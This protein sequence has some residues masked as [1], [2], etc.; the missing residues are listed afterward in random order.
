MLGKERAL[1]MRAASVDCMGMEEVVDV[2]ERLVGGGRTDLV[3][4]IQRVR[5]LYVGDF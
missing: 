5:R 3:M 4:E 2:C 1:V